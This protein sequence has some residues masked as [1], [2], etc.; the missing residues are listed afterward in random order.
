MKELHK[1]PEVINMENNRDIFIIFSST[2][3][4]ETIDILQ[5]LRDSPI[6]QL[7]AYLNTLLF[8]K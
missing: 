5:I 7:F 6:G 8:M 2:L 4:T 1:T 3:H